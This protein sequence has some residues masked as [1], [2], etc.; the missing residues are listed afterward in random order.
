MNENKSF[1]EG[2]TL[3]AIL[4]S[5]AVFLIWSSWMKKK[6]PEEKSVENPQK[7]IEESKKIKPSYEKK[8]K[9]KVTRITEKKEK[10]FI[11]EDQIWSFEIS[12]K[13]MSFKN[14][15]LEN[16]KDRK[17]H[18]IELA[19]YKS[20]YRPYELRLEG[21][22]K[23]L[24][25]E[26][27][28]ISKNSYL[29]KARR[30]NLIVEQKIRILSKEYL[31]ENELSVKGNLDQFKGLSIYIP[32]QF[33]EIEG[34]FLKS[35]FSPQID[36]KKVLVL[37]NSDEDWILPNSSEKFEKNFDKLTALATTTQYFSS[38][39]INKSNTFPK[40]EVV[41]NG[42]KKE[43]L[44]KIS[45]L[46]P[47]NVIL[48]KYSIDY[49][50]FFGPKES[51]RLKGL[52]AGLIGL[53]D[54]GF[55]SPIGKILLS[56]M[57]F[58]YN[59]FGNWGVAIIFL[60]FLIRIVVLPFNIISY[61]SMKKMSEVG[62]VLQSLR[63]KYKND[64]QKVNQEVLKIYKENNINPMMGCLPMLLQMPVFFALYGVLR[65]SIELYKA[66]FFLWIEDLSLAD[67]Y[68]IFPILL[69]LTMIFQQKLSPGSKTMEP[70]QKK[71]MYIML[72][73]FSLMILPLASGLTL[74]FF[75]SGLWAVV[76]QSIFYKFEKK[77]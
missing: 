13:G 62:P 59:I 31:V 34:G 28:K 18:K 20:E 27:Y 71:M 72:G 61:R 70:L 74:S 33:K 60:T 23:P 7:Q 10:K 53:L 9:V 52:Q 45:F 39:F 77:K 12:S 2:R 3:L 76:Q 48:K 14:V 26:I 65:Q 43:I 69:F 1:L 67:P 55:F 35:L 41:S 50:I 49:A 64:P 15:K 32:D 37:Q 4:M 30:G 8:Q 11:Y 56:S 58:F 46:V 75:I 25:F 24:D 47:Q 29:G 17:G 6:Y 21:D 68:Y 63:K 5:L 57:Q 16:Y 38:I 36:L 73:V 54:L 19:L 40:A 42:I 66:P 51:K 44:S 22:S